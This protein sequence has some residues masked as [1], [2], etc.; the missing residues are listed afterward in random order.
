MKIKRNNSE[1]WEQR[2]ST[3][4]NDRRR[5]KDLIEQ[6]NKLNERLKP[7]YAMYCEYINDD[8]Q[9]ETTEV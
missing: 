6:L 7:F 8:P 3:I 2:S 4:T 9:F 1:S 5:M